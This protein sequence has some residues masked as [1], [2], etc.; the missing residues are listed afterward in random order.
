ME[1]NH[2]RFFEY[3]DRCEV[4]QVKMMVL[5][6]ERDVELK[7]KT[8]DTDKDDVIFKYGKLLRPLEFEYDI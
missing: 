3:C 4:L 2:D 5:I 6:K 1:T 7:T 8:F